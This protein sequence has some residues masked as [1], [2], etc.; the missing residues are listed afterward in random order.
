VALFT[1]PLLL[2]ITEDN[3]RLIFLFLI[4]GDFLIGEGN[5][6]SIGGLNLKGFLHKARDRIVYLVFLTPLTA[7]P[8]TLLKN[9]QLNFGIGKCGMGFLKLGVLGEKLIY[10]FSGGGVISI[11]GISRMFVAKLLI[12]RLKGEKLMDIPTNI[13]DGNGIKGIFDFEPLTVKGE[14]SV[15][16]RRI[17]SE[18]GHNL[19]I[20]DD[21]THPLGNVPD[22]LHSA[23]AR[24]HLANIPITLVSVI[25]GSEQLSVM[26]YLLCYPIGTKQYGISFHIVNHIAYIIGE[27][28]F[29]A[30]SFGVKHHNIHG[31]VP[32]F[33]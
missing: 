8:H 6:L 19:I 2:S 33:H 23:S 9:G 20:L 1:A 18:S 15:I 32:L 30:R 5:S 4:N 29:D 10:S 13:I 28:F 16:E 12:F 3:S 11:L 27:G 7:Q 31:G 26:P 14:Y 22:F 24:T 17:E 21:L 25:C